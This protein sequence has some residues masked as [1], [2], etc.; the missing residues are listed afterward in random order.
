[1]K[2]SLCQSTVLRS[3][4]ENA[5]QMY[6]GGSVVGKSSIIGIGIS[7]T[8]PL[9]FTLGQKVRNLAWFKTSLKF[10]PPAFENA[11]RYRNYE[12]VQCCDDHPMS[13]PSLVKLGPRTPEKALSVLTHPLKMQEKTITKPWIIPFRSNCVQNLNA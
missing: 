3:H 7:P 6:F 9:I 5:H 8:P 11:A 10:V 12:K 13:W 4:A 2:F 1:M